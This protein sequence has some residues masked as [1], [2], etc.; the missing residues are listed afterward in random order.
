MA[1]SSPTTGASQLLQRAYK[2][3]PPSAEQIAAWAEDATLS[4]YLLVIC[5]AT[6]FT[7]LVW[8][9][10][11]L[12]TRYIRHVACL[13][14]DTQHYFSRASPRWSFIKR[15]FIYAPL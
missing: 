12:L 11:T 4:Q 1:S 3:G 9:V 15:N 6:A 14:N 8:R 10:V 2:A 7:V 13:S 5:G